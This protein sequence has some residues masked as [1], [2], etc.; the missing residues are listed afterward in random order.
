[1]AERASFATSSRLAERRGGADH[2]AMRTGRTKPTLL[3]DLSALLLAA[4]GLWLATE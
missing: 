2:G 3:S 1:M 4:I